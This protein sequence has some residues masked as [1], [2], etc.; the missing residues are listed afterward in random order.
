MYV[1]CQPEIFT[2]ASSIV[3][4]IPIETEV[5]IVCSELFGKN[6]ENS[7]ENLIDVI[8]VSGRPYKIFNIDSSPESMPE[9][10]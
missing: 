4:H 8:K 2:V 10:N 1:T 9:T 6:A 5:S 7:Q 3:T